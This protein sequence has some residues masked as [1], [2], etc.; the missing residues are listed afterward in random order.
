MNANIIEE[1]LKNNVSDVDSY[2]VFPTQLAADL[3][4]DRITQ[5][6]S[7]KAV[8]SERFLAWDDFKASSIKSQHQDKKAVPSQLRKIFT[9][10]LIAQ[11]AKAPFFSDVI[12]PKYA[13]NASGFASSISSLLPSL[14]LW[15]EKFDSL[16]KAP[17][18]EDK[19]LI[20][21]YEKYKTFLETHNLFEPA[22]ETPPFNR[23]GKKYFVF[24]PE[25]LSDYLEYKAI[26]NEAQD[27]TVI[28]LPLEE[29]STSPVSDCSFFE[30]SRI[31]LKNIAL[32]LRKIHEEKGISWQD[33][34]INVPDLKT[35]GDYI[36]RELE[37]FRIPHV[38]R[39]SKTLGQSGA[40]T[41]FQLVQNAV[42]NNFDFYSILSLLF[43][44][45]LPWK[46]PSKNTELI[47]L[48]K[49]NNCLVNF[50]YDGKKIDVWKESLSHGTLTEGIKNYY[51]QLKSDI[52]NIAMSKTFASVRQAYFSFR[53]HFFN[54]NECPPE[55]DRIL[56]RCISELG[57]L[58]DLEEEFPQCNVPSPLGFFIEH[59]NDKDYLEQTESLGVQVL[60]Y[61]TAA[62]APFLCHVIADSSQTS[63]SV[64][65]K[66]LP[67]LR[68]DKRKIFLGHE[69]PNVSSNFIRLYAMNSI[70]TPAFFTCAMQTFTSYAQVSSDLREVVCTSIFESHEDFYTSEKK[71]F[72]DERSLDTERTSFPQKITDIES[73]GFSSWQS[74]QKNNEG[75]GIQLQNADEAVKLT[76]KEKL[77]ATDKKTGLELIKISYSELKK[78]LDCPRS[79]LMSWIMKLEE[80]KNEAELVSPFAMGNLYHKILELYCNALR[81]KS[82]PI[83]AA[84][85]GLDETYLNILNQKT[86]EAIEISKNSFLAK[87]LIKSTEDS[88][89]TQ[90]KKTVTEFSRL[91]DGCYV[92]ETETSY[93]HH[94]PDTKILANGKID[95]LL[96]DD[97]EYILVDF[98]S[99]AAAIPKNI[100]FEE[101][102]SKSE[103]EQ[104]LPDFQMPMYLY[105]LENQRKAKKVENC[106]FFN[107]KESKAAYVLGGRLFSR[108]KA[109]TPAARI[110]E[111]D[112]A[113]FEKTMDVFKKTVLEVAES[114]ENYDFSLNQISPLYTT[115]EKCQYFAICRKNFNVSRKN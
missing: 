36:D 20:I 38:M 102:A 113:S 33:M 67:F 114:L 47:R 51:E 73:L 84:E 24:F 83:K 115:C 100:F 6:S 81:E 2:F 5:V 31:E 25:I 80:Q 8:A 76:A 41:F 105:L 55:S 104:E 49:E 103:S 18:D 14:K 91:F 56:S 35:M 66:E 70:G 54:M 69:D 22:W 9:T 30:N 32:Y 90:M 110:K 11:N 27:I 4:A 97:D 48:G 99:T 85:N 111:Q 107:I 72:Q 1:T 63:L 106:C 52:E 77:F 46:E 50:E 87:E 74:S 42:Q 92:Q 19:D 108:I 43:N 68:E 10:Q 39:S 53:G 88:L 13:R 64:V 57:S 78:Y 101:D 96:R 93:E 62:T 112:I 23:D 86:E 12:V 40:G 15:K 3:W 60:P 65:Y 26:L 109:I 45:T 17:D 16:N 59:L 29:D 89:K 7:T 37:L 61:K 98:K 58:I 79:F 75:K 71:W 95:C 82:L 44:T 28:N 34:A 21:L 94:I